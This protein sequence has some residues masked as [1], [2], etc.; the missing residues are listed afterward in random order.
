MESKKG[1]KTPEKLYIIGSLRQ[2]FE[3]FEIR[4]LFADDILSFQVVL[5]AREMPPYELL[6][7]IFLCDPPWPSIRPFA[8]ESIAW[9]N[10]QNSHTSSKS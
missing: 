7:K 9:P 2:F 5:H 1:Q 6:L 10:F 4:I 8:N 3:N